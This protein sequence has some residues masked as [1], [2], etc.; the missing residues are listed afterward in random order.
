[1]K[2]KI[3][4][5][6]VSISLIFLVGGIYIIST[7]ETSTSKL[8]YLIKLHQ[9]EI[10]REHLLLQIKRVQSDHNLWGTPRSRSIETVVANV[11]RLDK[12]SATCFDCH[13]S[14]SVT[15]RLDDLTKGIEKYKKAYSRSLTIR[16]NRQRVDNEIDEA[17]YIAE[18]LLVD[19]KNMVH[20]AASKLAN[21]T[22]SSLRDIYRTKIIIYILLSITPFLT[23]GLGYIII[24]GLTTPIGELLTATR[25][26]K[27]GD[28]DFRVE[29]LKDEF[30]EVAASFNSM[31]DALKQ[32]MHEIQESEKRYR[33]LFEGA[34]DA[35]F[36]VDAEGE[37]LGDIVEANPA[38]AKM[39]QYTIEELLDLNL[40]KDLDSP[41]A[42][43]GAPERVKRIMNGE[44][45]TEEITHRKKDGTVFPVEITAGLLEFMGHKYILAIDRDISNRKE[46]ENKVLQA[47]HD[48]EATF[49]IITDMIT[50]HD[51]D[52][53]II[54]ANKAAIDTLK[55]PLLEI[56]KVKCYEFYH[57]KNC[58]PDNCLSCECFNTG[59]PSSFETYETHLGMHLDVRA[60]PRYDDKNQMIGIV[61]VIRDITERKRVEEAMQR[62]QQMKIVGEWAAGLVHEIKNP[63]AGI[64]VSVEV[65][66]DEHN[67]SAEDR[68]IVLKAVDEIK[69]IEALLKSLLNFAR[70]PKLQ[71]SVVD[72]NDLL[73]QTIDFSLRHPF[74]SS[75]SSIKIKVMKDLDD[76]IPETMADPMQLQQVLLNLAFNSI[77]A[78]PDG[79]TLGVKS[80]YDKNLGAIKIE[81][82]DTGKGIDKGVM[83]DV[84]KPFFT[85]KLKGSG[86][87][88]A[89]TRQ[90]VEQ[91]GG[92]ISVE[93]DTGKGTVFKMLLNIKEEKKKI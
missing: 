80:I 26:L 39:H 83:D 50:I 24:R 40:I 10:L 41:D 65:L 64:K 4:I 5:F 55:L 93:S 25:K 19:V 11:R 51:G 16:A 18:K 84:F 9:V 37:N 13:H 82:S 44:W 53:N 48:W 74:L 45:V 76:T 63:L 43:N 77:E 90:I 60:M 75:N 49:N 69:R 6:L 27:A 7:I 31:A 15:E 89:I 8:D 85:T 67:I 14:Q 21:K 29:G 17:F 73:D 66:L 38:A 72:M 23:A 61:H 35:I 20:M 22:Q 36:L 87:G 62:A 70:P 58:P 28:L 12:M 34:G 78:M 46:M 2:K 59:K 92:V 56:N 30:G 54:R 88:L 79:G 81:I 57:G 47:K 71:L 91:H 1:M 32:H 3:I 68:G 33:V 42:A 86:L 52:F